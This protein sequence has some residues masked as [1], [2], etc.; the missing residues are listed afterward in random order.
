[1]GT[2][3]MLGSYFSNTEG[4]KDASCEKPPYLGT[5]LKAEDWLRGF[6][7]LHKETG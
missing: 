4:D 2:E 6:G 7:V 1:M 5:Y 3:V